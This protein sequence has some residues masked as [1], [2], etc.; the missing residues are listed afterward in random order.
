M[1]C[2]IPLESIQALVVAATNSFPLS[3][4][5]WAGSPNLE[6]RSLRA[7]HTVLA[8]LVVMGT[9]S[10]QPVKWS[11]A[12][13][14]YCLPLLSFLKGP[15]KSM[16]QVSKGL[17]G[18]GIRP[19]GSLGLG[20]TNTLQDGQVA[21]KVRTCFLIPGQTY[22]SWILY[23]V[24]SCPECAVSVWQWLMTLSLACWGKT[25]LG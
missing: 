3:L 8:F 17:V 7:D 12:V 23:S 11:T 25:S 24:F 15:T 1:W 16:P 21:K 6:V 14:R 2:L 19:L 10:A 9:A 22:T 18:V 20:G 5:M 13:N 4:T